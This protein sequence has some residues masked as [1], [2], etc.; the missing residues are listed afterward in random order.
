[1]PHS[2]LATENGAVTL[3]TIFRKGNMCRRVHS[4]AASRFFWAVGWGLILSSLTVIVLL[5]I[6]ALPFGTWIGQLF[7]ERHFLLAFVGL[8]VG[9]GLLE[10]ASRL[11]HERGEE[12]LKSDNRPPVLYL[13]SFRFER[14]TEKANSYESDLAGIFGVLGPALCIGRPGE[15]LPQA[16]FHRMYVSN[17]EWQGRVLEL[18][19]IA[20][21]VV[22]VQGATEGLAWELRTITETLHPFKL[23]LFVPAYDYNR[24]SKLASK[25]LPR[26]LPSLESWSRHIP[27]RYDDLACFMFSD[28]WTPIS[29]HL[30]V[31]KHKWYYRLPFIWWIASRDSRMNLC[32][33]L[34]PFFLRLVGLPLVQALQRDL[35]ALR[36][37]YQESVDGKQDSHDA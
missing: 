13:R 21:C 19:R 18:L 31:G 30:N 7:Q 10:L 25:S 23:V 22:F 37:H 14:A 8:I 1:M 32:E 2:S 28:D 34:S 36:D 33:M 24:L 17:E 35:R 5:I 12:I 26:P 11:R 9:T 16:T 20:Q 3:K 15:L 29:L 27:G 6:T 4:P